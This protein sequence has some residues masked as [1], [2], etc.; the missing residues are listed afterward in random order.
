MVCCSVSLF[1]LLC[2]CVCVCGVELPSLLMF[3][4]MILVWVLT[5]FVSVC[6]PSPSPPRLVAPVSGIYKF[7]CSTADTSNLY[8]WLDDHILC[9]NDTFILEQL[10]LNKGKHKTTTQHISNT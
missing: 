6:S 7:S 4:C 2:C 8:F 5:R 1:C 10:P 9:P 3:V